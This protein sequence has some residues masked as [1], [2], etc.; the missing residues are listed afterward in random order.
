MTHQGQ[1]TYTLIFYPEWLI[2]EF[3]R[4][5][6]SKYVIEIQLDRRRV[7]NIIWIVLRCEMNFN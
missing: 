6:L 7:Y 1:E 4:L 2:Y 3:L 5:V